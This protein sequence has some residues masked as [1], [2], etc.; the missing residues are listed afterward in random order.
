MNFANQIPLE[1]FSFVYSR[2]RFQCAPKIIYPKRYSVHALYSIYIYVYVYYIVAQRRTRDFRFISSDYLP[3]ETLNYIYIM[4]TSQLKP[5]RSDVACP[6]FDSVKTSYRC[7][8]VL[9]NREIEE[10][11]RSNSFCLPAHRHRTDS[12]NIIIYVFNC[13]LLLIFFRFSNNFIVKFK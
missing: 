4:Y 2:N 9:E 11:E 5:S 13:I 7:F 3:T 12:P 10:K 8:V 6:L 1:T